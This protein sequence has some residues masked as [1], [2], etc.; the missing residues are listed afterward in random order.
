MKYG[1]PVAKQSKAWK[2]SHKAGPAFPLGNRRQASSARGFAVMMLNKK[3]LSLAE[4]R[5]IVAAST[6]AG[7]KPAKLV[8][9]DGRY[10][11]VL[12]NTRTKDPNM[13]KRRS[14]K[15][16]VKR[17]ARR[18]TRKGQVRKTRAAGRRAYTRSPARRRAARRN[19]SMFRSPAARYGLSALAGAVAGAALDAASTGDGIASKLR[20]PIGGMS[21]SA[22]VTASI[23]TFGL[24]RVFKLKA[25]NRAMAT[26]AAI[27]MLAPAAINAATGLATGATTTASITDDF[28]RRRFLA[29]PSRTAPPAGPVYNSASVFVNDLIP[30]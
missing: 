12:T 10:S 18:G 27:G 3:Q 8:K 30:G 25:G 24:A 16:T 23:L 19:P 13:A 11:T 7:L 17:A 6:K 20:I 5:N 28:T 26:A 4:A 15:R 21:L 14:K 1:L 22:G 2:K 9:R 29:A